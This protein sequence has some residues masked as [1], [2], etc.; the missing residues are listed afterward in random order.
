MNN[1]EEKPEADIKPEGENK[2][3][4]PTATEKL[5]QQLIIAKQLSQIICICKGIN[6]RKVLTGLDGSL[7]VADVNKKVGTGSGGCNGER[8]GPKIKILLNKHQQKKKNS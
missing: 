7:S 3:L 1:S 6:L 2:D 4:L 8:C 5:D